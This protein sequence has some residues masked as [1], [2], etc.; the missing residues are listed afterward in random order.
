MAAGSPFHTGAERSRGFLFV[1]LGALVVLLQAGAA[2]AASDGPERI[3]WRKT[4]IAVELSV[5]TERLVHF[6]GAVKVG[7]PP[8]LQGVLR[9]QSIAG[10]LYLFAHRSFVSTRV[11]VRGVDDGRVYL[12][13]LSATAEGRGSG[14]IEIFLPDETSTDDEVSDANASGPPRY[15]Y[16]RLTRF[17][18]QQLYAPA[19]LLKA[20]PG[21]VRMPV[22]RAPV[23]LV[24]GAAVEAFPLIAWRAGDLYLTAVKLTNKTDRPQTLDPRTLRGRWL[25]ATFQHNRLFEAGREADRTVAYLVSARPFAASLR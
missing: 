13:D 8:P 6:P 14:P 20:L 25:A 2:Q 5:G 1:F 24:R 12:L 10:T 4:P 19:R 11:I 22:K 3:A 17:A 16:V 7:V 21:V 15:G 9:V 18:A 23:P